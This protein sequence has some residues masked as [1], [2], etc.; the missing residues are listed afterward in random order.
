VRWDNA[1][2][3][4]LAAFTAAVGQETS[5]HNLPPGFADRA[6]GDYALAPT[7]AMLDTGL[8]LPG[9]NDGYV[10]LAPDLG[11]FEYAGYG[12]TLTASPAVQAAAP[13]A[14]AAY[15]LDL[16][17]VGNF[18]AGVSLAA[19]SPA[20]SLAVQVSP[21]ALALPGQSTLT[22]TNTYAGPLLPGLWHTV[23]VTATG[24]GLTVTA[25]VRLLVGGAR[26]YLTLLQFP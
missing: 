7:S 8:A 23:P 4:T 17:A 10:G 26:L 5:G 13:G 12:F 2:Y 16:L 21:A 22:V 1:N 9:I 24:G 15:R 11:A 20:P 14:A 19:S 18:T 3:A 6:N 25:D